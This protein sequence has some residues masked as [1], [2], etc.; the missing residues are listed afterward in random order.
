[1][2]VEDKDQNPHLKRVSEIS[3]RFFVPSYQRGYRWGQHEVQALLEDIYAD[4]KRRDDEN[5]CLQPVVVKQMTSEVSSGDVHEGLP[6][7][8]ETYFELIDGQQ[9]LTTLYLVY[10]YLKKIKNIEP[11]FSLTYQTRPGST[12]YLLSPSIGNRNDNI[13][14]FHIYDAYECIEKWFEE[15]AT[16]TDDRQVQGVA[17]D[18]YAYLRKQVYVIW[19]DAGLQPSI[20]LFTRLNIGRI[21]L[22]NAE[23]VKALLLAGKGDVLSDKHRQIEI[24]TQWDAIE[25]ELQEDAFWAFLTNARGTSY[26][27][28]IEL[29]FDLLAEKQD[30]EKERFSTFLHF[31]KL[32]GEQVSSDA[33]KNIDSTEK[34]GVLT[35]WAQVL[36][37][38]HLL[39]EWFEDRERYHKVGYLVATGYKL[40]ELVDA[41]TNKVRTG[42]TKTGFLNFLNNE[43]TDR[44]NLTEESA[45]ELDYGKTYH[46]CADL[47][48]L[49]N[50]ESVRLLKH[51]SDR[52]PFHSHKTENW[53]LEHIHAQQ[54]E[55]LKTEKEW[56]DWLNDSKRTLDAIRLDDHALVDL[57]KTL[58]ND[59]EKVLS[60][61]RVG[62]KDFANLS[63]RIMD[64]R[65]VG[66]IQE[67]M[68][69]IAN[70]ALLSGDVNSALSNGAFQAKRLR[71][72]DLDRDG[73]FIP[74]CTKRV[75]LKYY[76][77]AG[78]Q[79]MHLW[80]PEDQKSYTAAML[81]SDHGVGHYLKSANI[82]AIS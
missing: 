66:S 34:N 63:L 81:S 55:P 5:Y 35:V 13:D 4:G 31:K 3:G 78:D 32:L 37:C 73:A 11:R 52:Y 23:L 61:E 9:R 46:K 19:Y 50:V 12:D 36:E 82:E 24:A 20:E 74:I 54:A 64:R 58:L 38:Y 27:T 25:R 57:K 18:V 65:L 28:R 2:T 60:Q 42:L 15:K 67:E 43:I 75:F 62:Q 49:F 77:K 1:M 80:G 44:L 47:L 72:N 69:S 70:L 53:S 51:S 10:Y 71:I 40:A 56:R 41:S 45:R 30:L 8:G 59:I 29:I 48:L 33:L 22:T 14:F 21:A 39:R 79:Q 26:P 16:K 7:A 68:H 6:P 17:D 76:T